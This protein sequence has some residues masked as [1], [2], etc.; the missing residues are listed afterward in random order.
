MTNNVALK[1]NAFLKALAESEEYGIGIQNADAML[2]LIKQHVSQTLAGDMLY[3]LLAQSFEEDD[4]RR[5]LLKDCGVGTIQ[6]QSGSIIP[7]IKE[8]RNF[9]NLGLKEA[10]DLC[11]DVK[12]GH[13][14]FVNYSSLHKK[15]DVL[16][17][18]RN[19]GALVE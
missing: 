11:V 17:A 9:S 6:N 2:D 7:C 14:Q 12:S 16:R 4:Q 18:F 3:E 1:G 19:I 5:V 8:V 15:S 13:P 10:K